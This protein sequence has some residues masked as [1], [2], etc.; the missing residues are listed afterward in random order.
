MKKRA[1]HCICAVALLASFVCTGKD[2][3]EVTNRIDATIGFAAA[4]AYGGR[5]GEL[6]DMIDGITNASQRVEAARF[7]ANRLVAVEF[8]IFPYRKRFEVAGAY[9]D[10]L[11][12]SWRAL[13]RCDMG[14][15]ELL[16]LVFRELEHYKAG[17]DSADN[18]TVTDPLQEKFCR[19]KT[20][21]EVM[22]KAFLH[23]RHYVKW[24]VLDKLYPR[25][26]PE[27]REFV[28]RHYQDLFNIDFTTDNAD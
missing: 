10:Y 15:S 11:R 22:K 5:M 9:I 26:T 7:F 25:L 27:E 28:K 20:F 21:I 23:D 17:C 16:A 2:Y 1:K 13:L 14:D 3:V 24:E 12:S 4:N 18:E 6:V 19:R 8:D